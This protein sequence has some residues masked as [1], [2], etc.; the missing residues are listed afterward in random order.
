M[1]KYLLAL[2]FLVGIQGNVT[3]PYLTE[4]STTTIGNKKVVFLADYHEDTDKRISA[5]Q[6]EALKAFFKDSVYQKT[7]RTKIYLEAQSNTQR[8]Y[9]NLSSDAIKQ[10]CLSGDYLDVFYVN[11]HLGKTKDKYI[12]KDKD[13]GI[14]IASWDPRTALDVAVGDSLYFLGVIQSQALILAQQLGI[15]GET[16]FASGDYF[17]TR[18]YKEI[19]RNNQNALD[20]MNT[21]GWFDNAC[22]RLTQMTSVI[23]ERYSAYPE[24]LGFIDQENKRI[25][26]NVQTFLRTTTGSTGCKDLARNFLRHMEQTHLSSLELN[27]MVK[28]IFQ[29]SDQV[30]DAHLLH[31]I[32]TD[33]HT[34]ILIHSGAAHCS[35]IKKYFEKM[36]YATDSVHTGE[37]VST[38]YF[39]EPL[40]PR[41]IT[42]ALARVTSGP[43]LPMQK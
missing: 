4:I 29:L 35:H 11:F 7:P 16:Y 9:S 23:A 27:E 38:G 32:L 33:E 40:S 8:E 18:F 17:K 31:C 19:K 22:A 1:K 26:E 6:R 14:D 42:Q 34:L 30:S 13:M 39:F 37:P 24:L 25:V 21:E 28:I 36:G 2:I 10:R 43:T 20:K 41:L 15:D 12:I 3:Y 5:S